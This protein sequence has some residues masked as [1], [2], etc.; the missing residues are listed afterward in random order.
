MDERIEQRQAAEALAM[1]HE[2]QERT[3]RAA[4]VPL[5]GYAAMFS[6][7][8]GGTATNDFVDITGAKVIA[9]LVLVIF[10]VVVVTTFAGRSA[11][12]SRLRGV[13]R[14]QTFAP[15][16]FL[17]ISVVAGAGAWLISRYGTGFAGD[18]AN[19]VGIRG[20][21]NTVF[22]VLCGAAFTALFALS[23]LLT[24][25]YQERTSR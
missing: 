18:I 2:H 24:T 13:Q 12:L 4:S 21:P 23:Q 15:P 25:A 8:A 3:R 11:P 22:G 10:A 19:A 5:W 1:V 20:Y 7:S 17:F 14:R 16:V 6:L 9:A